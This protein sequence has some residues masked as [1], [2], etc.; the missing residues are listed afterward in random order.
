MVKKS[1]QAL[2]AHLEPRGLWSSS[3][4]LEEFL[5][6]PG[7]WVQTSARFKTIREINCRELQINAESLWPFIHM[8]VY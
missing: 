5:Y 1:R 6:I 8:T 3:E 7:W 4:L 2:D